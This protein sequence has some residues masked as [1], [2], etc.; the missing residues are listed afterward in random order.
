MWQL[1]NAYGQW[2][3]A[4]SVADKLRAIGWDTRIASDKFGNALVYKRKVI[5]NHGGAMDKK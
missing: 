4:C 2:K 3:T 5:N 1:H